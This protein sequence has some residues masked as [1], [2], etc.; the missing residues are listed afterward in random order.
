MLILDTYANIDIMPVGNKNEIRKGPRGGRFVTKT[1]EATLWVQ[2][3]RRQFLDNV[4]CYAS[5]D[6]YC[7]WP[8]GI[9][10]NV[11]FSYRGERAGVMKCS[12]LDNLL[13][14][15]LDALKVGSLGDYI[16]KLGII[17]DDRYITRLTTKKET[18]TEERPTDR[19]RV[20][21]H[22]L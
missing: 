15:V 18:L 13:K 14:G 5:I 7:C 3:V 2:R 12:D 17:K 16:P 8:K 6:K 9:S 20:E 10:V 22:A 4:D 1:E 21:I 19:I 11:I